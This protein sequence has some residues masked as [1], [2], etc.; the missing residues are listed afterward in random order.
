[1]TMQIPTAVKAA[2]IQIDTGYRRTGP[3]CMTLVPEL[4]P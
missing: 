4:F 3:R 2:H 1:M